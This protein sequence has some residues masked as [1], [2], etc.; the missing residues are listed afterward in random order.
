MPH[1]HLKRTPSASWPSHDVTSC[2]AISAGSKNGP[3]L[4]DS[5][6]QQQLALSELYKRQC[7]SGSEVADMYWQQ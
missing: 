3:A 5:P 6:K 2:I 4:L 7:V 1:S